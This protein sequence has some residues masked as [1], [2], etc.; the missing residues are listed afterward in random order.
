MYVSRES[1]ILRWYI[2][3][4]S[5]K[6]IQGRQKAAVSSVKHAQKHAL[7]NIHGGARLLQL[8]GL[9]HWRQAGE[10]E[11]AGDEAGCEC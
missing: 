5:F 10:L 8:F 2:L 9:G 4:Q 7:I 1:S 6:S 3:S 11:Q